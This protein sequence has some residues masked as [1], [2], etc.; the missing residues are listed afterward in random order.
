MVCAAQTQYDASPRCRGPATSLMRGGAVSA[1]PSICWLPLLLSFPFSFP[2]S[3]A[4]AASAAVAAAVRR[5]RRRRRRFFGV[6][7][8]QGPSSGPGA[9]GN[10]SRMK[11]C[12]GQT[13]EGIRGPILSAPPPPPPFV[14]AVV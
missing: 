5:R 2:A 8:L 10:R 6:F 13:P 9:I 14:V 7:G 1:A 3:A 4:A 12:V 11:H